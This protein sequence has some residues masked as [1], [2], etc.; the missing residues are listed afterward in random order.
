MIVTVRVRAC[1]GK[2]NR[3]HLCVWPFD[4]RRWRWKR[5][6][7]SARHFDRG[8][9]LTRISSITTL[10]LRRRRNH[11]SGHATV[12]TRT[13]L[14]DLFFASSISFAHLRR[15]GGKHMPSPRWPRPPA[16]FKHWWLHRNKSATRVA[17]PHLFFYIMNRKAN[18]A[19]KKA[20]YCFHSGVGGF[21]PLLFPSFSPPFIERKRKG[22]RERGR[23]DLSRS[24]SSFDLLFLLGRSSRLGLVLHAIPDLILKYDRFLLIRDS[25][26]A[27]TSWSCLEP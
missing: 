19:S 24:V 17:F 8:H 15:Y 6:H 22:E 14:G 12:S 3:S 4:R 25:F 21:I 18:P 23:S 5:S 26:F 7:G 13:R 9:I 11:K 16:L 20:S 27:L 2:P 10:T 1:V